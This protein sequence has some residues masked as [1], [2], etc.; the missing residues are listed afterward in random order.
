[1]GCPICHSDDTRSLLVHKGFDVR[2][3]RRCDHL[4]A[5]GGGAADYLNEPSLLDRFKHEEFIHRALMRKNLAFLQKWL[6]P[7]ARIL[8]FGCGSGL[9]V[10]EALA[11]G[12]DAVGLD[13]AGWVADAAT[14]WR[15]PLH[16]GPLE[17]AGYPQESFDAIVSI[18][19]FEHLEDPVGITGRL[20]RL[21]KPGGI[22]AVL[23]IPHSRGLPWLVTGERWW[24]LEPPN[25]LHFFSR[26]SLARLFRSHGLKVLR[27]RTTG[28]GT[29]FFSSL[30][31]RG[32]DERTP[33]DR[34]Q[35]QT[36]AGTEG[37]GTNGPIQWLASRVAVPLV[38]AALDL[39]NLGNNLTMVGRKG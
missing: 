19:C 30:L 21:L 36:N 4:W 13:L 10:M 14:H 34:F 18:V 24:D 7:G 20:V 1:M 8:D 17:T 35:Q 5:D 32:R 27:T 15:L 28:V 16:V 37:T 12:Y 39:T 23:S 25:H 11:A 29:G 22:L 38:N 26:H 9:F 33:L 6:P 31:G 3:C 2:R